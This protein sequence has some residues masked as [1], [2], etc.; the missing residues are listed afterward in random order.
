VKNENVQLVHR[1]SND[2]KTGEG[3]YVDFWSE[4]MPVKDSFQKGNG[5]LKQFGLQTIN[6]QQYYI[7]PTTGQPRKNFLLQSGNN[8]IYFDSDTGVGTNALELQFAKGSV[9]SNELYHNCKE[10]Y[11][12]Q[13]ELFHLMNN[14]ITVMQLTVMMTRVSKM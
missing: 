11:N 13:R 12:L 3:N 9:S 10:D 4:L 14:T 5:P 7:D 1:F 6:G 2:V 8:W